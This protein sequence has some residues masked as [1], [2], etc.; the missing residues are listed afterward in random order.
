MGNHL[1]EQMQ[2]TTKKYGGRYE[3][4]RL[5]IEYSFVGEDLGVYQF[6]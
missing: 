2:I 1:V 5:N 4:P 3:W 6:F